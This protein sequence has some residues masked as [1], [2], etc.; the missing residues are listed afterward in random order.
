MSARGICANA[1]VAEIDLLVLSPHGR[2]GF[3]RL[4]RGNVTDQTLRQAEQPVLT[5]QKEPVEDGF[6]APARR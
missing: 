1:D 3:T 5:I 2:S 6:E 4:L